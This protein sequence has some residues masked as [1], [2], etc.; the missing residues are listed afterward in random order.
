M[1]V[2]PYT[3]P[4]RLQ[5]I[6]VLSL[7]DSPKSLGRVDTGHSSFEVFEIRSW[8]TCSFYLPV[9]S[10]YARTLES[11][12]ESPCVYHLYTLWT[13][14]RNIYPDSSGSYSAERPSRIYLVLCPRDGSKAYSLLATAPQLFVSFHSLPWRSALTQHGGSINV[15]LRGAH[16]QIVLFKSWLSASFNP[17]GSSDDVGGVSKRNFSVQSLWDHLPRL[18]TMVRRISRGGDHLAQETES[19]FERRKLSLAEEFVLILDRELQ[20]SIQDGTHVKL[21]F[22][23]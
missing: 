7:S 6:H 10:R 22:Q 23:S 19:D 13:R 21:Q 3:G 15:P 4:L 17:A 20:P 9:P 2:D 16:K 5:L 12:S 11:A 14:D 8:N 18:I 1:Q